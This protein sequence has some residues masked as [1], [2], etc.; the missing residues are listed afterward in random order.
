MCSSDL[1]KG[2][3]IAG[4]F[5][6]DGKD[7]L[8]GWTDDKFSIDL[9][10]NGFG[11]ID[12]TIHFGYI[13]VRERPIA[14]DIDQDGIDDLGLFVPDRAGQNPGEAAEWYFLISAD[15]TGSL[16]N[17]GASFSGQARINMLDHAFSPK[18]LG[19]DL[20][21]MFGDEYALPIIGN[22]DPP[23]SA[24]ASANTANTSTN[25]TGG[26]TN[27]DSTGSTGSNPNPDRKSTRL[28]SSH[29]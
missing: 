4:D 28:N 10:N 7:D 24:D 15:P 8:A 26:N 18:P 9:A 3:P 14:A 2:W 23:V 5:D 21:M 29:T 1:I 6:G 17:T 16:R 12:A 19:N 20:Y 27:T 22:F 11:Q 13:G 25:S